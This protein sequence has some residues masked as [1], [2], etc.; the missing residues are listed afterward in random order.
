MA[1]KKI[2]ISRTR[3][4]NMVLCA[5]FTALIT[6]GAFITIP[7]PVVPFTMQSTFVLLA[8]LILGP[9]WGGLSALMY[10]V[11]GLI[12][13]PIFTHGSGFGYVLKPTFGYIIGFVVGAWLTGFLSYR[14][15]KS[16]GF[17]R[18][19]PA[20]LAGLLVLYAIGVAYMWT[21]CNYV[22][23]A[24]M[25]A[26]KVLTVGF[27][28]T[29]PGDLVCTVLSV[30]VVRKLQPILLDKLRTA[31]PKADGARQA[32]AADADASATQDSCDSDSCEQ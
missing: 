31:E 5:L 3:T 22:I 8:G 17:A 30:V 20:A 12:G 18:L 21:L 13:V 25:S 10:L 7:I 2:H 28:M 16:P 11:L 4:R 19:F 6:A 27:L 24:P 15:N 32:V 1:I 29:L 26:G 14:G 9:W 23:D